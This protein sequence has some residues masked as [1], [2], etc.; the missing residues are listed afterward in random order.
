MNRLHVATFNLLAPCYKRITTE[1]KGVQREAK[2]P[3]LWNARLDRIFEYVEVPQPPL[4]ILMLQEFWFHKDSWA[5]FKDRYGD[6]YTFHSIQRTGKKED[7]L[8][9]MVRKEHKIMSVERLDLEDVGYRV[10]LLVRLA[11]AGSGVEVLTTNIHLSFPHNNVD[12]LLRLDQARKVREAIDRHII[13]M[14]SVYDIPVIVA[15]DFNGVNDDVTALFRRHHFQSAAQTCNGREPYVTHLNHRREEVCTDIIY[16]RST[17]Q[18]FMEP[19]NTI[20]HPAHLP[21]QDWPEEQLE[22]SDHRM[23]T[24]DF[25]VSTVINR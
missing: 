23:V 19:R 17:S 14:N 11:L 18:T 20:I 13:R 4:D 15:G 7:G 2:Y 10:A 24:A 3:D 22:I 5:R 12:Q 21:D 16:Y 8:V 6:D 1:D 25:D 9:T